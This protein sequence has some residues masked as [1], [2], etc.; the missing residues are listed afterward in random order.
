LLHSGRG[1]EKEGKKR[2][3]GVGPIRRLVQSKKNGSPRGCGRSLVFVLHELLKR[4]GR[5]GG[6]KKKKRKKREQGNQTHVFSA[7]QLHRVPLTSGPARK[8]EKKKKKGE[9]GGSLDGSGN[10]MFSF[11]RTADQERYPTFSSGHIL[12]TEKKGRGEERGGKGGD[13]RGAS[14]ID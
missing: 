8:R 13:G 11:H 3:S 10:H 9:K 5:G 1:K 6:E 14:V 4:R 7:Q 2:N 12:Y